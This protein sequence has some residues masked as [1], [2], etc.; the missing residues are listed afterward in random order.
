MIIRYFLRKS[1]VLN[2]EFDKKHY[3]MNAKKFDNY[4]IEAL[5]TQM[6]LNGISLLNAM[7]FE[8]YYQQINKKISSAMNVL[9]LGAGIGRHSGVILDTGA[10]LTTND[11][12]LESLRILHKIYPQVSKTLVGDMSALNMQ[13]DSVDAIISCG[14]LSYA[15]PEQVNTE[16]FRI[17]KKD[18]T[19]IICDSLNHNIVYKFN[20]YIKFLVGKRSKTSVI[21][22]PNL[23]RLNTLTKYFNYSE[24]KFF[25]SYLWL[26]YLLQFFLS[27]NIAYKINLWL[28]TKFPSSKYAFKFVL[29][30]EG[31]RGVTK[32]EN[33]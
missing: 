27:K 31:F 16:I 33:V 11:V 32:R 19:L 17:L 4:S 15:D 12:S 22:I 1:P 30:C 26:I 6:G 28:E 9:E 14:S 3:D 25:G 29:V 21:R 2:S 8:Y 7:P 24:T 18:G 13:S 10:S 20:R 5:Q 23:D